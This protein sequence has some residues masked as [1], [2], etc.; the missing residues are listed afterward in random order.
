MTDILECKVQINKVL[1]PKGSVVCGDWGIVS[2]SPTEIINGEPVLD[3]WGCFIGK[4]LLPDISYTET[5]K[6]VGKLVEDENYGLQYEI[7]SLGTGYDLTDKNDQKLFLSHILTDNQLHALYDMYSNPFEIIEKEDIEALCKV[8]G[9]GAVTAEKIIKKYQDNID[10]SEILVALDGYGLTKNM[11]SNLLSTY[12]NPYVVINKIK[13]NPYILINE[14]EGIGWKKADAIAMKSGIGKFSKQRIKAFLIYYFEQEAQKGNSW[15]YP[16]DILN[17]TEEILEI[18]DIDQEYFKEILYEL[19][20]EDTLYWDDTKEFIALKK[21]FN[22]ENNVANELLRLLHSENKFEYG[23]FNEKIKEIEEKQG[24]E[25]DE[26]QIKAIKQGLD[27]N[28]IVITGGAGTG[29]TTIVNAIIELLKEKYSFVQTALSGKAASRMEEVTGEKGYTIHKLLGYSPRE[30]FTYTKENPM[31]YDI[32]ILDEISMVGGE[33]FYSL[34]QAIKKD[35]KLI[36]IGDHNQL[37]PIGVMNVLK[38]LIDSGIIPVAIL[39]KIHRQAAK[40]GIITESMKVKDGKQLV[41]NGWTGIEIRGELQDFVI[42][43]YDDKILTAPK[44]IEWVKSEYSKRPNIMDIQVIVPVKERGD[45][46]TFELNNELQEIFN[47]PQKN[48]EEISINKF[49]K[50]YILRENDKVI[51]VVNCYNTYTPDGKKEPI[52]NGYVGIIKGIYDDYMIIDFNICGEVIISEKIYKNIELA[53]ACTVHKFQ[54]SQSPI[55]IFGIDFSSYTLLNKEMIYTGITRASEKCI[56]CAENS[57]LRHAINNSNIV[58]KQTFLNK[59]LTIKQ[60]I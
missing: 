16:S 39:N 44:I 14:V 2:L 3:S 18:D 51:N 31:D 27:S 42:D 15:L 7:I 8:Y 30:G 45:A 48:K 11:I 33:L 60:S 36:M 50:K 54:G 55:I 40:S 35:A 43:S 34:I 32:I 20:D 13:E 49:N 47:P 46:C 59:L 53:Y 52:F 57:A 37:E 22:L 23:D 10:Y 21:Y 26:Y 29:K 17:A 58:Q 6:F 12:K 56:L 9:I 41:G 25:F 4:G 24:F 1:Y 5:Y 28:V 19:K 38:D